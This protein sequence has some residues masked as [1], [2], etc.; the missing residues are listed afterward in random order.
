MKTC[1][2]VKS[3]LEKR[4]ERNTLDVSR[5]HAKLTHQFLL[6]LFLVD[7][8]RHFYVHNQVTCNLGQFQFS[9]LI[10]FSFVSFSCPV[11]LAK[12]SSTMLKRSDECRHPFLFFQSYGESIHFITKYGVSYNIFIDILQEFE[13][14]SFCCQL[15]ESF[16][17]K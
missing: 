4:K 3:K 17:H 15:S 14:V 16:C 8:L 10:V 7:S 9:F 1:F 13:E 6:G 2:K 12:T 5:R 11:P